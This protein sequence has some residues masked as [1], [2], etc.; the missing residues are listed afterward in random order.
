MEAHI[1][2]AFV[3]V[4]GKTLQELVEY[5]WIHI[6]DYLRAFPEEATEMIQTHEWNST[7]VIEN[8]A[9]KRN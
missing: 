1:A 7:C 4:K 8:L 5:V 2:K 9:S 3:I 6:N